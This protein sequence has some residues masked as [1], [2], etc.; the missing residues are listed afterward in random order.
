LYTI[1]VGQGQW[2]INIKNIV[3]FFIKIIKQS[4][5]KRN[6]SMSKMPKEK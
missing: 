6:N 2:K 4:A 1:A 3:E 5:E